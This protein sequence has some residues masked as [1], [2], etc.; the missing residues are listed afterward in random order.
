MRE[1]KALATLLKAAELGS[2]TNAADDQGITSQAASKT[3]ALLERQLGVKLLQR[4]TR[5]LALMSEGQVPVN[6]SRPALEAM[7]HEHHR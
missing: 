2:L 4:T 7:N 1:L 5:R 6:A 3:L